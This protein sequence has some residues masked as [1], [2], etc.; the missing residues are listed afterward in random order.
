MIAVRADEDHPVV[1]STSRHVTQGI[2]DVTNEKWSGNTLSGTSQLIANDPYELRIC[3]PAGW[4]LAKASAPAT[5]TV[6]LVRMTLRSP[7]TKAVDWEVSFS[8]PPKE[9]SSSA[10][11]R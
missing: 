4:K 6:G 2:I 7:T 9:V 10:K 3:V 8:P 5:Q 1:I 11:S